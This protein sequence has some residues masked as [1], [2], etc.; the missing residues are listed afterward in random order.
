MRM[1]DNSGLFALM[2][3]QNSSNDSFP[4]LSVSASIMVLST[5]CCELQKRLLEAEAAVNCHQSSYARIRRVLH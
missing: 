3:A 2:T 5:I 1:E 4:S